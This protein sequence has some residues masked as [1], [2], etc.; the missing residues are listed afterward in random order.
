MRRCGFPEQLRGDF[1]PVFYSPE[2]PIPDYFM[3]RGRWFSGPLHTF[4]DD[5]RQEFFWRRPAEGLIVAL[6]A[7]VCTAPD[8]TVF[9][10]DAQEWAAYQFFRS[11]IVAQFWQF[12]GVQV[13]PVVQ[14]HSAK[15]DR[16]LPGSVWATRGPRSFF[17]YDFEDRLKRFCDLREP[18]A[19]V[20]FGK[21][22]EGLSDR[23]GCPVHARA[24]FSARVNNAA[25][26]EGGA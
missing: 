12:H 22:P 7:G 26:K 3:P 23:I 13:M 16:Y 11:L 19:V 1:E 8:F 9:T 21:C 20:V 15:S 14:F 6:S 4:V 24:L 25:Q 10:D 18:S 17:D 2:L 5:Y